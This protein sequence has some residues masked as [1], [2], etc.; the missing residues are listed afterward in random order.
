MIILD[1]NILLYAFDETSPFHGIIRAWLEAQFRNR[2]VIG[3]PWISLWAFLRV[4]TNQRLNQSALSLA[5]AFAVIRDI[6]RMPKAIVVQPGSQHAQILSRIASDAQASGPRMTDA[7]LAALAIEH[8]AK[9]ASTDRDFSRFRELKWVN[10]L[11]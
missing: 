4:A 9:L 6:H 1:A 10:P 3:L 5:E 11:D 8:G 2:E 7:V